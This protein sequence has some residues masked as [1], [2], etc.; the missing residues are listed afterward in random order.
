MEIEQ[1]YDNLKNE[2]EKAWKL[3]K[4]FQA[5]VLA[6]IS[7]IKSCC[8]KH[9]DV[10]G[11]SRMSY[12]DSNPLSINHFC[13]SN[14]Y[15]YRIFEHEVDESECNGKGTIALDI[16]QVMEYSEVFYPM[17]I[18]VFAYKN[19]KVCGWDFWP[20][21]N[22]NSW[23]YDTISNQVTELVNSQLAYNHD[24]ICITKRVNLEH[25]TN[26]SE[27]NSV[28]K[29]LNKLFITRVN[30]NCRVTLKPIFKTK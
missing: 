5:K 21:S 3:N 4:E 26:E 29:K 9:I 22:D 17:L 23:I 16:V 7:R 6:I 28:L 11:W 15:Q 20:E 19:E 25:L 10:K 27:I 18:F 13:N 24:C 14:F 12:Y 1:K 2:L 30:D 8:P